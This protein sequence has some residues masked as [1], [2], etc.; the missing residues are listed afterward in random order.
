[1]DQFMSKIL[2]AG[3]DFDT[4]TE[5]AT[6]NV[7]NIKLNAYTKAVTCFADDCKDIMKAANGGT[8]LD[9]SISIRPVEVQQPEAK[10]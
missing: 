8:K 3:N 4:K 1:M 5:I 7:D 2:K 9:P 6:G 10:R